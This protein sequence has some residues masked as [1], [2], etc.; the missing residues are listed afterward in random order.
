MLATVAARM[1]ESPEPRRSNRHL[2]RSRQRPPKRFPLRGPSFRRDAN[3]PFR[4]AQWLLREVGLSKPHAGLGRRGEGLALD[5]GDLI[6]GAAPSGADDRVLAALRDRLARAELRLR[7]HFFFFPERRGVPPRGCGSAMV[8]SF[9]AK[10]SSRTRILP[11][12]T[13]TLNAPDLFR[14]RDALGVVVLPPLV[15]LVS[16][17]FEVDDTPIEISAFGGGGFRVRAPK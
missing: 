1:P 3:F 7:S 16:L 12:S 14:E 4:V 15:F 13:S 5:R 11:D 17:T 8:L 6:A 9:A 10:S 2:A